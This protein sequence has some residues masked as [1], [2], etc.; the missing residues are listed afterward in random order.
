MHAP[1]A[2]QDFSFLFSQML[3]LIVRKFV[4]VIEVNTTKDHRLKIQ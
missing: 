1:N 3:S 2:R 4:M